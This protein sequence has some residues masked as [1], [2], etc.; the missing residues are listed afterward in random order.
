MAHFEMFNTVPSS[1]LWKREVS[2]RLSNS[3]RSVAMSIGPLFW[4]SSQLL[5]RAWFPNIHCRN[6]ASYG[7]AYKFIF[8]SI[9]STD[10]MIIGTSKFEETKLAGW[11]SPCSLIIWLSMEKFSQ[12]PTEAHIMRR[13]VFQQSNG[14][15][16]IEWRGRTERILTKNL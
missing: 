6:N 14:R 16:T 12:C 7:F 5:K 10:Y 3:F 1:L 8:R 2:R 9:I 15:H 4:R 13:I 11:L